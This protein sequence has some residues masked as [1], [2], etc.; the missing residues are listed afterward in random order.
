MVGG[1]EAV[2]NKAKQAIASY[3]KATTLMG[4]TVTVK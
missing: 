4:E 1:N 3:A 2:F